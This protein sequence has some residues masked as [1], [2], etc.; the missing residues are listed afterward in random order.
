MLLANGRAGTKTNVKN[1]LELRDLNAGIQSAN[2]YGFNRYLVKRNTN[3]PPKG[4]HMLDTWLREP[5]LSLITHTTCRIGH[6]V[7]EFRDAMDTHCA[8]PVFRALSGLECTDSP[9][10]L[11]ERVWTAVAAV[12]RGQTVNDAAE[13]EALSVGKLQLWVHAARVHVLS[14]SARETEVR[15]RLSEQEISYALP[16]ELGV[17]QVELLAGGDR[18]MHVLHVEWLKKLIDEAV[19]VL[20]L[21]IANCG[22]WVSPILEF[23]PDAKIKKSF[24]RIIKRRRFSKGSVGLMAYYAHRMRLPTDP[25]MRHAQDAD[26]LLFELAKAANRHV[27]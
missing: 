11:S 8:D 27:V 9:T 18:V 12:D 5:D 16:G 24:R 19:D 25:I 15:L 10:S 17:T 2:A 3:N 13:I 7:S 26:R 23:L 20:A 6:Y 14:S 4:E 1:E 21:D 22:N